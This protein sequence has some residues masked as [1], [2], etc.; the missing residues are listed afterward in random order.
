[1]FRNLSA[2]SVITINAPKE[3]VLAVVWDIKN[4]EKFEVKA[5]H[6][7]VQPIDK[8]KGTYKVR[9]H[10]A[11]LPWRRE[12]AYFLSDDGFYSRDAHPGPEITVQGGFI[13]Q[14]TGEGE[15][16]LIHYEMYRLSPWFVPL[17]PFINAYL[18]WS[19]RKEL[20]EMKAA[21]LRMHGRVKTSCWLLAEIGDR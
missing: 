7:N 17:K 13:V 4:I 2:V 16:T 6:V 18:K 14:P 10:F 1:M 9:G 11:G 20:G 21:V 8:R 3:A 15:C 5:D 19:I 12:F